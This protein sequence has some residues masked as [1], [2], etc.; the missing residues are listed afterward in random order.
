[1]KHEIETLKDNS[2]NVEK[3]VEEVWTTVDDLKEEVKAL[4]DT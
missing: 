3:S 4:K 2:K 1:M